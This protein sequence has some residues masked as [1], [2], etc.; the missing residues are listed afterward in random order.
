MSNNQ[1]RLNNL[2]AIQNNSPKTESIKVTDKLGEYFLKTQLSRQIF[3]G[4]FF[5]IIFLGIIALVYHYSISR[6]VQ[7]LVKKYTPL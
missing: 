7:V 2:K 4:M 3:V 6:K 5:A 1:R